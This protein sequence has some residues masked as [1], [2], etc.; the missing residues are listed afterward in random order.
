MVNES[1]VE[2]GIA[3]SACFLGEVGVRTTR[4]KNIGGEQQYHARMMPTNQFQIHTITAP[5]HSVIS[6]GLCAE[7][8]A[9]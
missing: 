5:P 4:S 8:R 1:H 2:P 6:V 3:G 7:R 9:A